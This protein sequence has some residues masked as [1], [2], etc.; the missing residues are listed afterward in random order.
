M[1][2]FSLLTNPLFLL[3][4]AVLRANRDDLPAIIRALMGRAA[5]MAADRLHRHCLH[6][7]MRS[8]TMTMDPLRYHCP[9]RER[10]L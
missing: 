7:A 9:R 5:T 1:A 4:V 6:R 3:G 8:E 2:S 10:G